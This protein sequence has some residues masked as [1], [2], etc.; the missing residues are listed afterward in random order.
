[1]KLGFVAAVVFLVVGCV[2]AADG[3]GDNA[4]RGSEQNRSGDAVQFETLERGSNAGYDEPWCGVVRSRE[5]LEALWNR[6]Y[7]RRTPTPSPP[8]LAFEDGVVI[9]AF[10]GRRPTGG[11]AIEVNSVVQS[12]DELVVE[13]SRRE[14]GPGEIVT[15]ALTSPYHVVWLELDNP[16]IAV[17]FLDCPE[18]LDS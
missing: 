9:A 18:Q 7:R 12:G 1:M 5:E 15:Q 3:Q 14:P 10:M 11:Y 6:L 8:E 13:I 17:R 16:E 4:P 2:A